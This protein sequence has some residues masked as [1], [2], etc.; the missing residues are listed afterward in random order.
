VAWA[1][2]EITGWMADRIAERNRGYDA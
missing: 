2:S 1:Q